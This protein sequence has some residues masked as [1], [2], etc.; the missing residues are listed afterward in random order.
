VTTFHDILY[1]INENCIHFSLLP[2]SHSI[3]LCAS[4]HSRSSVLPSGL[5]FFPPI[6]VMDCSGESVKYNICQTHTQSTDY[7]CLN[8]LKN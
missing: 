4:P 8:D 2:T 5:V 6:L 7:Q 1:N 3:S